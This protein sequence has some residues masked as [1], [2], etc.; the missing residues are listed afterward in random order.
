MSWILGRDSQGHSKRQKALG[1]VG[2]VVWWTVRNE[3]LY[4]KYKCSV[5]RRWCEDRNCWPMQAT[6]DGRTTGYV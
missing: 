6:H 4:V 5:G 1:D 2:L 3:S